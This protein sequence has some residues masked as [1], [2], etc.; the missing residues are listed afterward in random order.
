MSTYFMNDMLAVIHFRFF[1]SETPRR[2]AQ[3]QGVIRQVI[4]YPARYLEDRGVSLPEDRYRK[5][6]VYILA[7]IQR[8]IQNPAGIRRMSYYLLHSVQEHMKHQG[9]R[10]YELA[11]TPK[12]ASSHTK[13]VLAGLEIAEP[14]TPALAQAH[15]ILAARTQRRCK[16]A[17]ET[18]QDLFK[19][20]AKRKTPKS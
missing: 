18:Q 10:Y 14:I 16:P 13:E 3:E 5:L 11:K 19:A 7:D 12:A 1:G 6:L 8:N 17:A 2:W 9:D 15:A 20:P 4:T